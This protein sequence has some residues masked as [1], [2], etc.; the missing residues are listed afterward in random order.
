MKALLWITS[1]LSAALLLYVGMLIVGLSTSRVLSGSVQQ[2]Y[3]AACAFLAL[4]CVL[5][6]TLAW[7]SFLQGQLSRSIVFAVVPFA[8]LGGAVGAHYLNFH[9]AAAPP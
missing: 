6:P 1:G 2:T 5:G 4:S 7:R 3:V 8:L 9:G